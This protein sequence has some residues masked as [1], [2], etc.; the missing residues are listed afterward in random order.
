MEG[1][2]VFKLFLDRSKPLE[3]V[4]PFRLCR[5]EKSRHLPSVAGLDFEFL[6]RRKLQHPYDNR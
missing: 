3:R 6:Q 1:D 4:V 5:Q 2:G